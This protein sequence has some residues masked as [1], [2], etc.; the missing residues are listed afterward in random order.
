MMFIVI[1][2]SCPFSGEVVVSA[3]D[4]R[5]LSRV[6]ILVSYYHCVTSTVSHGDLL[7]PDLGHVDDVRQRVPVQQRR[8]DLYTLTAT[9]T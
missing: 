1:A 4:E 3:G 2:L 7:S 5:R 8:T 6:L 9:T